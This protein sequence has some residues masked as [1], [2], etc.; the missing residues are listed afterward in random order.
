VQTTITIVIAVLRLST[1]YDVKYLRQRALNHLDTLYPL[2]LTTFDMRQKSRTMPWRLNTAFY[3][4]DLAH[5]LGMEWLLPSALYC[6]CACPLEDLA[7]GYV[8]E[9]ESIQMDMVNKV[10]CLK[11][12]SELGNRE[13][14]DVLGFL[15]VK[16]VEGCR[17]PDKC[18]KGRLEML[19]RLN[20]ERRRTI[21][22][23][24]VMHPKQEKWRLYGASVCKI[25]G[26]EGKRAYGEGKMKL[27]GA[28]P[29]IF[30]L[31]DWEVLTRSKLEA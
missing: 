29:G 27:W 15:T 21:D 24:G 9:G 23:L 22:P 19:R 25:C 7:Q 26:K 18:R 5:Q 20:A 16:E 4:A 30:G 1:K 28:L 3:V 11:A 10:R 6:V 14:R 12:L 17:T 31:Q 2:T 8:W 13:N